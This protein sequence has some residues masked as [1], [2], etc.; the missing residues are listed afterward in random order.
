M[1]V[2]LDANKSKFRFPDFMSVKVTLAN[3]VLSLMEGRLN[4]KVLNELEKGFNSA[5]DFSTLMR[6]IPASDR[7]EVLR[8]LGQARQQLSPTK[9]N[10]ITQGSNAL[11]P[12]Q[13]NQNALTQNLP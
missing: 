3:Q 4:A 9:L 12:T 13:Q 6:K 10:L 8:A 5:T 11:A 2:I 1:K 7:I